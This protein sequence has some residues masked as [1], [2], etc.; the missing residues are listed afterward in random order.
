MSIHIIAAVAANGVVGNNG[1]IPWH[2]PD[3]LMN[4]RELTVDNIVVMGRGTFDSLG[5]HP[6]PD[7]KNIVIS[8]QPLV[9]L[10]E[11]TPKKYK[12]LEF[13]ND[14]NSTILMAA[15]SSTEYWFIG[16]TEIWSTAMPYA[17]TM[18]ICRVELDFEGDTFFP[19]YNKQNWELKES[20]EGSKGSLTYRQEYYEQN[21]EELNTHP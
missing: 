17:S 12:N 10:K 15:S 6:L 2:I 13:S 3:D 21:Q 20:I 14:L 9:D 5:R 19:N 1:S 18:H 4:F 11:E 8:R 16:G 7:R